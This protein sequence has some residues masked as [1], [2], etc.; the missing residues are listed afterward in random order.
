M[1]H[2]LDCMPSF[3]LPRTMLNIEPSCNCI[4]K[5]PDAYFL[6]TPM[7]PLAHPQVNEQF[8][9]PALTTF[10][11]VCIPEFLS[12]YETERLVQELA[13]F[14]IDTRNIVINQVI[15]PE[16]GEQHRHY[17]H[18]ILMR[19][20]ACASLVKQPHSAHNFAQYL[21]MLVILLETGDQSLCPF[22]ANTQPLGR[23]C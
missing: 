20:E 5:L 23:A 18:C 22:P 2:F 16:A 6:L 19:L 4:S 1:R 14:C 8:Q 11:C 13:K 7:L 9:D 17:H 10:V 12:L 21:C 3:H 15:F